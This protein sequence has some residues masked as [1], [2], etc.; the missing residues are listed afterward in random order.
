M[1]LCL[2]RLDW[3][4]QFWLFYVELLSSVLLLFKTR[5]NPFQKVPADFL[6]NSKYKNTLNNNEIVFFDR[7]GYMWAFWERHRAPAPPHLWNFYI[8]ALSQ[9]LLPKGMAILA[10]KI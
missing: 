7:Y 4:F 10:V 8:V 9:I 3:Y 1:F 6:A 5:I 2:N